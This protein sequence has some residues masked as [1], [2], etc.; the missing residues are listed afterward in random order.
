MNI[1]LLKLLLPVVVEGI[2]GLRNLNDSDIEHMTLLEI[3][4][5]LIESE[6]AWPELDFG[7]DD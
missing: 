6:H 5:M 1:E 4:E 3:K 2:R 7:R